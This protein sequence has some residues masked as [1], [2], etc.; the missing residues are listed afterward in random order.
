[1]GVG[2]VTLLVLNLD[3][4]R[5][6]LFLFILLYVHHC[7]EKN[8]GSCCSVGPGPGIN[9]CHAELPQSSSA[10]LHLGAETP[11]PALPRWAA[12]YLTCTCMRIIYPMRSYDFGVMWYVAFLWQLLKYLASQLVIGG[13]GIGINPQTRSF[14]FFFSVL[15]RNN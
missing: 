11:G 14:H 1:M 7:C 13:A 15:W 4:K 9:M 2:G 5:F 3:H 10:R 12:P 8:S 6:C